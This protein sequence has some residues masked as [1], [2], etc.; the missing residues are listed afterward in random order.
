LYD[1]VELEKRG[2]PTVAV[3]TEVFLNSAT[4]HA[5]SL[6]RPDYQSVGIKHPIADITPAE[7][8]ERAEDV[9]GTIVSLLIG[10]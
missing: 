9:I 1:A 4:A 2:V 8:N 5:L 6:G 10:Q 3:H 7:I